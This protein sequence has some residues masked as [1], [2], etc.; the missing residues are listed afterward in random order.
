MT[1][2]SFLDQPLICWETENQF[3]LVSLFSSCFLFPLFCSVLLLV[4]KS[5]EEDLG[6]VLLIPMFLLLVWSLEKRDKF[7]AETRLVLT[8]SVK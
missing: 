1:W 4:Y 2:I 5:L 8:D 3:S 6:C 7:K